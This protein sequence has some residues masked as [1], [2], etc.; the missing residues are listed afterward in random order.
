M[1]SGLN[2]LS[3]FLMSLNTKRVKTMLLLMLCHDAILCCLS[4]TSN[5]FGLETIKEQYI[6]DADFKDV[7]Q[8]CKEGRTWN[9]F[10]LNDGFVFRTNKL[11]ILDSSVR[12]LLL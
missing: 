4:L 9:K 11:C 3:L 8:N 12:L 6:H 5:F 1:L 7:L 2:L 10:V